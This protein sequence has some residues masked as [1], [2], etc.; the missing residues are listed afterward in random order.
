MLS[1]R[2]LH[3]QTCVR[4]TAPWLPFPGSV[5]PWTKQHR[6]PRNNS[7]SI[8]IEP[9]ISDME[10]SKTVGFKYTA[11]LSSIQYTCGRIRV[12]THHD[13][14]LAICGF[15]GCNC[16]VKRVVPM[17]QQHILKCRVRVRFFLVLNPPEMT[18][19]TFACGRW[20]IWD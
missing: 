13:I 10:S 3:M 1:Y 17:I 20:G 12:I 2:L 7:A 8:M 15:I 16:H 6:A 18:S 4:P 11:S 9:S 5:L 19:V 14:L